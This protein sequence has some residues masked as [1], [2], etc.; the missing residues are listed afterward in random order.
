[1][2]SKVEDIPIYTVNNLSYLLTEHCQYVNNRD[3]LALIVLSLMKQCDLDQM[4]T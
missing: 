2:D 4:Q 1:M 3:I